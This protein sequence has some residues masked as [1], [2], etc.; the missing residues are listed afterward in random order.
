MK[1]YTIKKNQ[2]IEF[3]ENPVKVPSAK[4]PSDKNG[5]SFPNLTPTFCE[6]IGKQT[7]LGP[8]IGT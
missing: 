3:A 8:C 5:N 6:V 7:I 4:L 1:S 2:L